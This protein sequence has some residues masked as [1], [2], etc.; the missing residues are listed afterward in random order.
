MKVVINGMCFF[1]KLFL[2]LLWIFI[3]VFVCVV[4]G[5]GRIGRSVARAILRSKDAMLVAINDP[6]IRMNDMVNL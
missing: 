2:I 6:F 3:C 1:G 5:F 4:E